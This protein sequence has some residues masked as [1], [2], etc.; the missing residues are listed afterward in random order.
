MIHCGCLLTF[1][2][3]HCT[4]RNIV[5]PQG[6]K[7]AFLWQSKLGFRPGTTKRLEHASTCSCAQAFMYTRVMWLIGFLSRAV[8]KHASTINSVRWLLN[9]GSLV[10]TEQLDNPNSWPSLNLWS[11]MKIWSEI[12]TEQPRPTPVYQSQDSQYWNHQRHVANTFFFALTARQT[13]DFI[14]WRHQQM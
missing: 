4:C 2:H 7:L 5:M 6:S 3:L 11:E 9:R 10:V 14:A 12:P 13:A 8:S 1:L